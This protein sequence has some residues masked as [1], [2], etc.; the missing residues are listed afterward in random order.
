MIY[1]H[2]QTGKKREFV[3]GMK[4]DSAWSPIHTLNTGTG[5]V[6]ISEVDAKS[7]TTIRGRKAAATRKKNAKAKA[8]KATTKSTPKKSEESSE[9]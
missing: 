5:V 3:P 9:D 8:K 1:Q 6:S 2:K 7:I 4:I